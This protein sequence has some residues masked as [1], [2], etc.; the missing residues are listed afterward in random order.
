M[1]VQAIEM[2]DFLVSWTVVRDS[3]GVFQWIVLVTE[4]GGEH[5]T[6]FERRGTCGHVSWGDAQDIAAENARRVAATLVE[7]DKTKSPRERMPV[8]PRANH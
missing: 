6:V 3:E 5:G 4:R 8:A 1:R 2:A 7:P